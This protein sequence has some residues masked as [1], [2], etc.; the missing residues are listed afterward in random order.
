VK[1]GRGVVV[2]EQLLAASILSMKL[3]ETFFRLSGRKRTGSRGCVVT[4]PGQCPAARVALPASRPSAASPLLH[5]PL[6]SCKST[7]QET[8][9]THSHPQQQNHCKRRTMQHDTESQ[10]PPTTAPA[11]PEPLAPGPTSAA[12]GATA[13]DMAPLSLEEYRPLHSLPFRDP[14]GRPFKVEVWAEKESPEATSSHTSDERSEPE[15]P[16]CAPSDAGGDGAS[17]QGLDLAAFEALRAPVFADRLRL[18]GRPVTH[19]LATRM[20]ID[21]KASEL[22]HVSMRPRGYIPVAGACSHLPEL[23]TMALRCCL[24]ATHHDTVST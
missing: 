3:A 12:P 6:A 17:L 19:P 22:S 1:G 15:S 10:S 7:L 11:H 23:L 21:R 16:D 18:A 24:H 8:H 20:L 5:T 4:C 2:L 14:A 9:H 13:I